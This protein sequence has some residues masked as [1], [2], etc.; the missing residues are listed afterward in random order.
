[1]KDRHPVLTTP[2]SSGLRPKIAL[3]SDWFAPRRGGIE[4][5]LV[6]LGRALTKAGAH[7]SAIT[8]QPGAECTDF[9]VH[10]LDSARLP[11]LDLAIS[12]RLL[13]RMRST[14]E[15]VAP[16]VVHIH[17]S[18]VAPAC[19]AGLMAARHVGLPVVL[20]VHSDLEALAPLFRLLGP[21]MQG[22]ILSA[23]SL[24]IA[25]QLA[26]L[27]R[28]AAPLVL[29][30]GFDAGFWMAEDPPDPPGDAFRLVSAMRLE[31]KKRPQVLRAMQTTLAAALDRPVEIVVAGDGPRRAALARELRTPGWLD[32]S[33][34]RALYHGAHGFVMPSRHES[35]GIAALEARAAGLPVI[36]RAGNGLVEFI[37]DGEDGLLCD[38][39]AAMTTAA[40]RLAR[41]PALWR[42]LSGPR[43][44]LVRY[45]WPVVAAR[46]LEVYAQAVSGN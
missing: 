1:M 15:T 4:S 16:D 28:G 44:T 21:H 43:P 10:A 32:R 39:D 19:L 30:N 9:A 34:L 37:N 2:P 17:A 35:F 20:T 24:R 5:H 46:H 3:V 14:L 29:P 26:P 13:R 41:E 27:T 22:V 25:R 23:V 45:D 36:G 18:I 12:P 33:A 31:R 11:G 6:G 8:A 42:H 38:S 7:V 40:L